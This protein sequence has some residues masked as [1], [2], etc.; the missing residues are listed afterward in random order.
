MKVVGTDD[1]RRW[2]VEA[3]KLNGFT[4]RIGRRH[5]DDE[6]VDPGFRM[7]RHL[8][9][10]IE[11]LSEERESLPVDS[12]DSIPFYSLCRGLF[13]PLS[14]LTPDR[15]AAAFGLQIPPPPDSAGRDALLTEFISKEV[16]ISLVEKLGCILGDVFLGKRS[17]VRRDSLLRLLMSVRMISRTEC[18]D[19]LTQVGDVAILFAESRPTLRC[20][21]PLT[22]A[23]V[24]QRMSAE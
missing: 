19:R 7:P 1:V 14:M 24:V 16:G 12:L 4:Q 11:K 6:A 20:V 9:F 17:T 10:L 3:N 13:L 5:T 23:E 22:A 21:L 15:A 8:Q 2:F 18:L